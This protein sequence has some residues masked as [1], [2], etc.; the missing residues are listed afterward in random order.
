MET[1][2]KKTMIWKNLTAKRRN[3][4]LTNSNKYKDVKL[5]IKGPLNLEGCTN[6]TSLPEGLQVG[7]DLDLSGCTNLTSL[8]NGLQVGGDLSLS[9]CT[10]LTS[11]PY[12]LKVGGDLYLA[13]KPL[14]NIQK[15]NY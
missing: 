2:Y 9:G 5:I 7:E 6:L 14:V 1:I 3:D 4:L 8:P 10:N 11:L 13:N 15:V 12:G